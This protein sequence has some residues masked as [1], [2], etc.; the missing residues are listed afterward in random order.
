[1]SARLEGHTVTGLRVQ[2]RHELDELF[3]LHEDDPRAIKKEQDVIKVRKLI[4]KTIMEDLEN[5]LAN[6][7]L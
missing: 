1:M 6:S 3:A 2:L 4:R 7:K 5:E